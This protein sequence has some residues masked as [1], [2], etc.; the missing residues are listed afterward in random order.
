MNYNKKF[1]C[2]NH[3]YLQIKIKFHNKINKI[4]KKMIIIMV[5]FQ[6]CKDIILLVYHMLG[7]MI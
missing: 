1:E 5:K 4:I 3:N 7:K 6:Q 2:L